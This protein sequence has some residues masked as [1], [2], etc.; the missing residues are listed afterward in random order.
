MAKEPYDAK[1]LEEQVGYYITSWINLVLN[2]TLKQGIK[3]MS[4]H[5]YLR[6]LSDEKGKYGTLE[7]I[8]LKIKPG[9]T[10]HEPWPKSMCS[11]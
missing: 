6:K 7:D 9:C 11:R 2:Q 10:T 1:Y 5:A 8:N 3:F 4:F